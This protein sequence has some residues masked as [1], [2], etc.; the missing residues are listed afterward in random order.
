MLADVEEE[1]SDDLDPPTGHTQ[2]SPSVSHDE[3]DR[4]YSENGE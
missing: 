4:G 2:Y 3:E 1:E